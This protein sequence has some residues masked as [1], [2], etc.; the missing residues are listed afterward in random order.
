MSDEKNTSESACDKSDSRGQNEQSSQGGTEKIQKQN[1]EHLQD[2]AHKMNKRVNDVQGAVSYD[3]TARNDTT[4]GDDIETRWKD[5]ADDYRKRYPKITE[6]DITYKSGEFE[7][8]INRIATRT[9]RNPDEINKE[10]RNWK[11]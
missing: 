10:I 1:P 7:R 5:I 2:N 8:M 11:H 6:E 3:Q 4:D 9:N